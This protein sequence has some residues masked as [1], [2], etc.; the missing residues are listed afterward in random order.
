MIRPRLSKVASGTRLTTDLVNDI[1]NR[2]E[3]AADLLRQYKLTAGNGMYVEPHYDG[4]RVSYLQPVGGGATPTQPISPAFRVVGSCTID[5]VFTGFVYDNG[6]Y[7][8]FMVPGST[9]TQL[10]GIQGS[11][12]CGYAT[13]GGAA[14]GFITDL[15]EVSFISDCQQVWDID[16]ENFV[17]VS[18][19]GAD[20]VSVNGSRIV[21]TYPGHTVDLFALSGSLAVGRASKAGAPPK[22]YGL[23]FDGSTSTIYDFGAPEITEFRGIDGTKISGR[24]IDG[25][26]IYDGSTIQEIRFPGAGRTEAYKIYGTS[27]VGIYTVSSQER[28]FLYNGSTYTDIF[29][30]GSTR[31][32][33][34]GIG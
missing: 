22:T 17:G 15:S 3:Y 24:N 10:L 20:F 28:G 6:S 30:P 23:I 1:I 19:G 26:F 33:A 21:P 2:T 11:I 14:K 34:F 9:L 13:I 4:T 16:G 7:T 27:V 12:A 32:I 29:V 31:T 18:L 5:G 25:G 8:T